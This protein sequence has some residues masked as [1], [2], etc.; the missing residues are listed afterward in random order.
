MARKQNLHS[1]PKGAWTL[2]TIGQMRDD[3]YT[4]SICCSAIGCGRTVRADLVALCA[5]LGDAYPIDL[6]RAKARCSVCGAKGKDVSIR[7]GYRGYNALEH[8]TPKR[9]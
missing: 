1:R 7:I 9:P 6:V 4:L 8:Q 5:R 3:G 2:H